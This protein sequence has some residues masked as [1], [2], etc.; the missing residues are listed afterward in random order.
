MAAT[1]LGVAEATVPMEP[2][3][4]ALASTWP[5]ARRQSAAEQCGALAAHPLTW[6]ATCR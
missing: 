1:E 5:A 6:V 2:P 4:E 3:A